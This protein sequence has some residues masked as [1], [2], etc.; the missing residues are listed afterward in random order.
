MSALSQEV[1]EKAGHCAPA[2]RMLLW[3]GKSCIVSFIHNDETGKV[4]RSKDSFADVAGLF[5]NYTIGKQTGAFF[6]AEEPD[7]E[8]QCSKIAAALKGRE[9]VPAIIALQNTGLFAAGETKADA[10][11]II[12]DFLFALKNKT[13]VVAPRTAAIDK[14]NKIKNARVSGKIAIITGSAQG[15]GKGIAEALVEE[16]ADIII[17]DINELAAQQFAADVCRTYGK[18]RA[19]A[20]GVDVTLESSIKNLMLETVLAYGG[21]DIF[22]SNAGILKAGSIEEM[23]LATFELVTKINYSAYYLG[24]KYASR[25]M[26]IQHHFDKSYFSDIIQINSKSGLEGSNRNFAYAGGKFGGIG[27]TQSF[28]LELVDHNIKVNSVCPGN[29][30]EGPLWADPVNGLFAQYLRANK[31]PGAT[32]IEDVKRFYENKV[33][34]KRGCTIRD[35]ASAVLYLIEQTYETGQALPVTGGQ[36][37]LK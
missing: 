9:K 4:L 37:M 22:I 13:G 10:D 1:K 27:L 12:Q 3:P 20:V 17:A 2:I 32:T 11:A 6:I 21:I 30:F 24:V 18:G 34:M 15:F 19:L 33:P 31:V 5:S 28:A 16:G 26:K 35:V 8:T 14:T 23:D 7:I 36:V 29:F 25:Y